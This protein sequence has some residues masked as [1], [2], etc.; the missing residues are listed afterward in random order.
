MTEDCRHDYVSGECIWCQKAKESIASMNKPRCVYCGSTNCPYDGDDCIQGR[1]DDTAKDRWD[2]IPTFAL[3]EIVKVLTY[4]ANK[5]SENGWRQVP[6]AKSRYYAAAL[7]HLTAWWE[8][9]EVDSE[10]KLK[11]LA[12][13]GGC[14][15]FLLSFPQDGGNE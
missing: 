14:I 5:Y 12:H 13:A 11:H 10:S 7:R 4:G 6:R 2:L 15:L 3:R 8:G 9:E 1:K